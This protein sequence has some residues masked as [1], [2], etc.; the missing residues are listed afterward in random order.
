MKRTLLYLSGLTFSLCT[1][2]A[3]SLIDTKIAVNSVQ[4]DKTFVLIVSNENYKYEQPV[5][6]A[7]NDGNIFRL[8][9]ENTL[10]IPADNI[11]YQ[12]DASLNDMQTQLWLL[13]KKMKAFDGEARAIIYYSGHGMPADDGKS[14]YLLPVD[15]NS[16][17]PKSGLNLAEMYHSLG[18]MP[19][20]QTIVIMDACF[21]GARRDGQMLDSSRGVAI[22][23]RQE[24]VE[25]NLVVFS[26]AQGNETAYPYKEKEHGL[27]TYFIL[28]QL[29]E[30]GGCISLGE[31]SDYVTKQVSRTSIVK[32]E[33][34]QTP[35]VIASSA[36]K[37]WRDWK[38]ADSPATQYKTLAAAKET[39]KLMTSTHTGIML[40]RDIPLEEAEPGVTLQPVQT[41]SAEAAPM[42]AQ[43]MASLDLG[44]AEW[45]GKVVNSKPDGFGTMMF[46]KK[47]LIDSNDPD[48]NEAEAGDRIEGSYNDGHLEQGTWYKSN[49]DTE[50]LLIGL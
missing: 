18:Q 23:A 2:N 1:A 22:K 44:Y 25:G 19:S 36:N 12:P 40:K 6:Y 20:R 41:T 16:S 33:K 32:N 7:L 26:A 46:K 49:G 10:G 28:E 50:L 24:P 43:S 34:S 21:S 31:L 9:C 42:T 37:G 27:F 13:E 11:K 35:A 5:P 30:H 48:K 38:L 45:T 15:G 39:V 47:H 29:Q 17:I 4:D 14:A 3:Q 8:Y